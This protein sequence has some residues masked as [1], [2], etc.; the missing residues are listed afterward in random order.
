[1]FDL[2]LHEIDLTFQVEEAIKQQDASIAKAAAIAK[3]DAALLDFITTFY[4]G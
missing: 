2:I 3:K 1:M 4:S